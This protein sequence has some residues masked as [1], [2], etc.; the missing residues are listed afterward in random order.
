MLMSCHTVMSGSSMQ[1]QICACRHAW[2]N[3]ILLAPL[4]ANAALVQAAAASLTADAHPRMLI[5]VIMCATCAKVRI[6]AAGPSQPFSPPPPSPP[7]PPPPEPLARR[8][9]KAEIQ[10]FIILTNL[11]ATATVTGRKLNAHAELPPTRGRRLLAPLDNIQFSALVV[12]RLAGTP[13][14]ATP[15]TTAASL[16]IGDQ[17]P[18]GNVS[19][20]DGGAPLAT[21]NIDNG[22]GSVQT[23]VERG[24]HSFGAAFASDSGFTSTAGGTSAI[25]GT[26]G[27]ITVGYYVPP[28]VLAPARLSA[29][30]SLSAPS[31]APGESAHDALISA[32]PDSMT[33]RSDSVCI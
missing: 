2:S 14:F 8:I 12:P 16:F 22:A 33:V 18:A 32:C 21:I 15:P 5:A 6:D 28:P 9:A 23:S 1:I 29:A 4:H 30:G 20:Y 3:I 13:P 7:P 31:P 24:S 19:V 27:T 10:V 25:V 26:D 11:S 17:A